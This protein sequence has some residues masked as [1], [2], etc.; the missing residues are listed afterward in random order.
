M[1]IPNTCMI[2]RKIFLNNTALTY[3][4]RKSNRR[5]KNVTRLPEKKAFVI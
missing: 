3:E 1:A 5:N 2:Y 4:A